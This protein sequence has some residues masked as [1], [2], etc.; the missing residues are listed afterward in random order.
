MKCKAVKTKDERLSEI[1]FGKMVRK[2]RIKFKY[3][4]D[5]LAS[6]AS[7]TSQTI[8]TIENHGQNVGI[9]TIKLLAKAFNMTLSE[10]FAHFEDK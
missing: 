6:R 4:Q 2:L 5:E 9:G 7:L 10:F 1:N 8:N 3:T